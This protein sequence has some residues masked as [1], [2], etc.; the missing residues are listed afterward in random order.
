MRSSFGNEAK[1]THDIVHDLQRDPYLPSAYPGDT[2]YPTMDCTIHKLALCLKYGSPWAHSANLWQPFKVLVLQTRFRLY[3]GLLSVYGLQ[4][5]AFSES[6]PPTKRDRLVGTQG[7]AFSGI[8]PA[9]E[10]PHQGG[11][12]GLNCL[13]IWEALGVWTLQV[14][15]YPL[16]VLYCL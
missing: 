3:E 11:P 2:T 13:N 6:H 16:D 10:F 7:R 9:L 8:L 1:K 12:L 5:E 14:G 4:R 15:V